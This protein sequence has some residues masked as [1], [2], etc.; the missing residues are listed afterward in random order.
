MKFLLLSIL[1]GY[2]AADDLTCLP[3]KIL[4]PCGDLCQVTC[5]D[6]T[7]NNFPKG[8]PRICKPPACVCPGGQAS[9]RGRCVDYLH[10]WRLPAED[11]DFVI[12]Y[13]CDY[14]G[15]DI[16]SLQDIS[17][18][19]ECAAE[20]YKTPSCTHLTYNGNNK[21]CF[22]KH[23]ESKQKILD[24]RHESHNAYCAYYNGEDRFGAAAAVS[25]NFIINENCDYR[26]SDISSIQNMSSVGECAAQCYKLF[27]CTHVTYNGNNKF[28]FLKHADT[29]QQ[30]LD[31]R[32]DSYNAWCVYYNGEDRFGAAAAIL[33]N[34]VINEN[35][36]YANSDISNLQ[37]ISSVGECVAQ[38]YKIFR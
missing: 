7:T 21:I 32:Y 25:K 19:D 6:I 17:S 1:C 31:K 14:G 37:N 28:C 13:N 18:V 10:C 24:Q 27:S 22:L 30:I 2:V 34:F 20:C 38:C 15:F 29:K 36:D 8:C 23:A 11:E 9:I 16:S 5:R 12:K 26:G 4:N 33:K 35:C 3:G